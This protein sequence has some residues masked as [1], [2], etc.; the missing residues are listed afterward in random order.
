E[1][2]GAAQ[3]VAVQ[4]EPE[5]VDDRVGDQAEKEQD[6][7]RVREVG[8]EGGRARPCAGATGRRGEGLGPG[9]RSVRYFLSHSFLSARALSAEDCSASLGVF[10]LSSASWMFDCRSMYQSVHQG[11]SSPSRAIAR[12]FC[13]C[14]SA[15]SAMNFLV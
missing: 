3:V 7:R 4:A 13:F 9:H 5:R 1:R 11:F 6:G 14:I 15:G 10:C 8:E 12:L 2:V